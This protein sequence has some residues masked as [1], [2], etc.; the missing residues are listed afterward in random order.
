MVAS[1]LGLPEPTDAAQTMETFTVAAARAE[2]LAKVAVALIGMFEEDGLPQPV[3]R[4]LTEA[5]LLTEDGD[6]TPF[7]EQLRADARLS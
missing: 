2:A 6:T 7:V 5:E 4:V 3:V 1:A